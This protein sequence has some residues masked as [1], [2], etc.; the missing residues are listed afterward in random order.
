MSETGTDQDSGAVR[1]PTWRDGVPPLTREELAALTP[2]QLDQYLRDSVIRDLAEIDR[3]PEPWRA[4]V[5]AMVENAR[6]RAE[7]RIAATEG[8]QAS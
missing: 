7:R 5:H 1:I 4:R 8:R 6:T 2:S 3:L